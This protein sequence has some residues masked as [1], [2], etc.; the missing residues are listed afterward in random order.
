NVGVNPSFLKTEHGRGAWMLEEE[1]QHLL[2][3][4]R[5]S[6]IGVGASGAS[7]RPGMSGTM[8]FPVLKDCAPAR[9][10]MDCAGIGMSSWY[11][12]AMHVLLQICSP[13]LRNDMI[14][15]ARMHCVV[16]ISMKNN[17]RDSRPLPQ[18]RR[19]AA[20]P[21]RSRPVTLPH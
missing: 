12:T 2:R 5:P 21:G 3:G 13:L 20:G 11:P 1:A 17:G 8:D 9:V 14:P 7:S 18:D 10:G 15:V 16:S 6:R 19:N 4:V